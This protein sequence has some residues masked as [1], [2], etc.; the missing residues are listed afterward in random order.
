M[1]NI[2]GIELGRI[3]YT[4]ALLDSIKE[5]KFNKEV[6]EA[7]NRYL[8]CDWSEMSESE[9]NANNKAMKEKEGIFA[10]YNTSKG[11]IY[12][13]TEWNRSCT[14]ILFSYEY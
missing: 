14:T 10:C 12:I 8:N 4:V 11:N 7:F 1:K 3:I 2:R 6:K 13:I 5:L 9:M